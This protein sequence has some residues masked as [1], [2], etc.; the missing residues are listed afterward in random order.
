MRSHDIPLFR[1]N[2]LYTRYVRYIRCDAF[3]RQ[4]LCNWTRFAVQRNIN[5]SNYKTPGS[6]LLSTVRKQSTA[7]NLNTHP[8]LCTPLRHSA[9]SLR[10]SWPA[11]ISFGL[12]SLNESQN[13]A[14]SCE[15][16]PK[17][18]SHM[19]DNR[20]GYQHT[21]TH[22]HARRHRL[23]ERLKYIYICIYIHACG[24]RLSAEHLWEN[25]W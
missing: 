9:H 14:K 12:F 8:P 21:H 10:L 7:L 24:C 17:Y 13:K 22:I 16:L 20:R 15:P 2:T 5:K 25:S 3:I 23:P 1:G 6:L 4:M 19:T 18:M 11:S